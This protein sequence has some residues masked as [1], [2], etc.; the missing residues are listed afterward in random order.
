[1][2]IG[3]L[4]K[5]FYFRSQCKGAHRAGEFFYSPDGLF[6][7]KLTDIQLNFGIVI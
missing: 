2:H 3:I 7:Q 6:G 1:M 5:I 4:S